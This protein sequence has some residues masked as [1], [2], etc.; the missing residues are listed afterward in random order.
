MT[1]FEY[2]RLMDIDDMVERFQEEHDGEL[3]SISVCEMWPECGFC[4][5]KE[6]CKCQ[7]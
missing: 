3:P 6:V 2:Y 5:I 4:K 1:E 7:T